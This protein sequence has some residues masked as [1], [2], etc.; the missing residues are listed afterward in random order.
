MG[1]RTT[2][3]RIARWVVAL[4]C[5]AFALVGCG[6]SASST[7]TVQQVFP[8]IKLSAYGLIPAN[9]DLQTHIELSASRVPA[10]GNLTATL[11][12][13]NNGSATIDLSRPCHPW[14]GVILGNKAIPPYSGFGEPHPGD[15]STS[16]LLLHP[17]TNRIPLHQVP[18]TAFDCSPPS[19]I[20]VPACTRS[21]NLPPLPTGRYYAVLIGGA[22]ALPPPSPVPVELTASNGA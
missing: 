17:G 14:A 9:P 20:G 21:G 4:T 10:G 22:L 5:C 12:V 16:H 1:G 11:V 13:V 2:L 8:S 15:C 18:T 19:G 7:L 6:S 3:G